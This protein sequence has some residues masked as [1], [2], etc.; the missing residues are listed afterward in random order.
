MQSR[1]ESLR[2]ELETIIGADTHMVWEIGCG[3]GHFL[4]AYARAHPQEKCIGIDISTERIDRAIRKRNRAH[5]SNLHFILADARMFL[6]VLPKKARISVA[7]ALF[8]D[9][10]PKK[11][12]QKHRIMQQE[13]LQL[14]ASKTAPGARLL[15][16]T[17]YRPYFDDT[18]GLL[19]EHPQWQ[20]APADTP[21]P[22]EHETVFQSRAPQH[23]SLIAKAGHS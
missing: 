12:H 4:T 7:F 23:F 3:H 5:L 16:R 8:P 14:L 22:F 6:E 2:E 11:R 15:F 18:V 13:F 21:W 19:R 9:P 1:R 10:W 17:D 20:L